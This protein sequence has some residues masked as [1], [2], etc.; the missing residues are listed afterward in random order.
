MGPQLT[1]D[2]ALASQ[3][4]Q[5][6]PTLPLHACKSKTATTSTFGDHLLGALLPHACEHIAIEHMVQAA[7]GQTFAG[8]TRWIS[9]SNQTMRVRLSCAKEETGIEPEDAISEAI[10]LLN[11]LLAQP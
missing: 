10:A 1:V 4:I 11:R 2:S 3:L 9:K 6:Y 7:P 8:N 5:R